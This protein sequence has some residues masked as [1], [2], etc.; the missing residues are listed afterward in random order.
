MEMNPQQHSFM[1]IVRFLYL[2]LSV[3]LGDFTYSHSSLV[4]RLLPL[5]APTKNT[6]G[7]GGGGG[8][9]PENEAI[10]TPS[11]TRKVCSN[12]A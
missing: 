6:G 10:A 3:S 7:G 9:E 2:D 4:P 5:H 1:S 11:V 12:A 8:G